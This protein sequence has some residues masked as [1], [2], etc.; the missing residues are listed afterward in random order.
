MM[1][2]NPRLA[3]EGW[4]LLTVGYWSVTHFTFDTGNI[5]KGCLWCFKWWT[6]D[7]GIKTKNLLE[8]R[9]F[10]SRAVFN[11]YDATIPLGFLTWLVIL[12]TLLALM[13]KNASAQM[14]TLPLLALLLSL[15]LATPI[16]YWERYGYALSLSA[17]LLIVLLAQAARFLVL[18]DT[19]L[20]SDKNCPTSGKT[21][22]TLT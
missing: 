15:F 8:S 16:Q 3:F 6:K 10:D 2:K 12:I 14:A 19:A 22:S 18:K 20:Y 5:S 9:F 4:E 13:R 7:H 21:D 11:Q 1:M 17:P